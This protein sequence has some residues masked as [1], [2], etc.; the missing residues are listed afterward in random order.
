[1][2]LHPHVKSETSASIFDLSSPPRPSCALVT[3]KTRQLVEDDLEITEILSS[4]DEMEIEALLRPS[5]VSSDSPE[6]SAL[7]N[8]PDWDDEH[9]GSAF[10]TLSTTVWYDTD[11]SKAIDGPAKINR[12][13]HV[14]AQKKMVLF[15][16]VVM[17]A[18]WEL[19]TVERFFDPR[20]L[21]TRRVHS[22]DS[23]YF[24]S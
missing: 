22:L 18:S 1:M 19:A 9:E 6:P 12:Q 21:N 10:E 24:V 5:D 8:H 23:P 16:T 17:L 20:E 3:I 13:N 4:D 14:A 7:L 2:R 11:I 15:V